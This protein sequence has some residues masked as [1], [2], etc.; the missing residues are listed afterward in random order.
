MIRINLLP[1]KELAKKVRAK[2]EMYVTLFFVAFLLIACTT[3]YVIIRTKNSSLK[4]QAS[5]IREEIKKYEKI[6]AVLGRL[7]A[8]DASLDKRL[9]VIEGLERSR[10]GPVHIMDELATNLPERKLWLETL[11]L[12]DQGAL[13]TLEGIA[14]D[15]QTIADF[16]R[17]LESSPYFEDVDLLTSELKVMEDIKLKHFTIKSRVSVL[18]A[19]M[20]EL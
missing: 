7:K 12:K 9:S 8:Q 15:N 5:S 19:T 13:L 6:K 18:E 14:L 11:S 17:R 16:M 2:Q 3:H 10:I 4:S 20:S 1:V